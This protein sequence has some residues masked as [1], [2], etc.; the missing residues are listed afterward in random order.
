M[1]AVAKNKAYIANVQETVHHFLNVE[2]VNYTKVFNELT[3]AVEERFKK[4][5]RMV[6]IIM[7]SYA[8]I[9]DL[10]SKMKKQPMSE[11]NM[12]GLVE[13][14]FKKYVQAYGDREKEKET[15][16]CLAREKQRRKFK[17]EYRVGGGLVDIDVEK[18]DYVAEEV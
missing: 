6:N 18:N 17:D 9:E 1:E 5:Q 2:W 13:I 7:V 14:F 15:E 3:A 10:L 11:K 16:E 8:M 12:E 4:L